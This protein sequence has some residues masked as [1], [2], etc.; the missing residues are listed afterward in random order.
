M[1]YSNGYG[2]KKDLSEAIKWYRLAAD[3]EDTKA[4]FMLGTYYENGD[5]VEKDYFEAFKWYRLAADHGNL[6]AQNNLGNCYNNG[7]GVEKD[8]VQ[9]VMWYR[10]AAEQNHATAQY[11]LG[12][13]YKNGEGV[14]KDI[15]QAVKWY[16]LAAEKGNVNAQSNLGFSFYNGDG[17]EKDFVQAVKWYSLAAE[18]G[19]ENAQYNLG[20]CYENGDGVEKDY[21][22]AFKWYQLS[23]E[24][25]NEY[26]Q[27]NLGVCYENG[28]G[29]EKDYIQAF[30]WYQLS[31]EQGNGNAQFNLGDCYENGDGVE[32]DYVQAVNWFRLAAEKGNVSAQNNLGICYKKGQGVE[33][34][35]VQAVYWYR[36]AAEKGNVS[37]QN[38]LG[39]CFENGEGVEKDF[40][41][42]FKWYQLS[43][44]QGN[45]NAQFNLGDC[46]YYGNGV[47][48][49]KSEALK[50]YKL[51]A[52]QGYESAIEKTKDLSIFTRENYIDNVK[53]EISNTVTDID[54]NVYKTVQIGNQIWMAENLRVSRYRNGDLIPNIQNNEEWINLE[55]GA[56][57]NYDNQPAYDAEYGKHYNWFAVNDKRG[58]APKGW[59]VPNDKE[60]KI[61]IDFLG[62]DDAASKLKKTGTNHWN[63][64]KEGSITA[65]EFSAIPCGS[66]N[67]RISTFD[68]VG[69][70]SYW[71]TAAVSKTSLSWGIVMGK[72]LNHYGTDKSNGLSVRCIKDESDHV[73][74]IDS[75]EYKTVQI[76]NQ[77]WMA[78]N[79]KVSKY[80]NGDIIH[81]E[82]EDEKWKSLN[83]GACCNYDNDPTN[84]SKYGKLYNW[85]AVDDKRGL[86]PKGWHVP[87]D[88]EWDVLIE[89]LGYY[90][91]A[92]RKLKSVG[93]ESWLE[94]NNNATNES[95]FSA[96][97]GGY[98]DGDGT[99]DGQNSNGDWWSSTEYD[100]Y[101][102][103]DWYVYCNSSNVVRYNYGKQCGFSVRCV[104]DE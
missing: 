101:Y 62:G 34:D 88:E 89:F 16:R 11:N 98:R 55:T 76:G 2:V 99:F 70:L 19:N 9:A 28:D 23:A 102:A 47:T 22:Q 100:T 86:A 8:C 44:E 27:N 4:Q 93:N 51:S 64:T 77:V 50:W 49:D 33:K 96:L 1:Y 81:N 24:Q 42:A 3:Q 52:E 72:W 29:V 21:I 17:I 53:S 20:V 18:Q 37:A 40:F 61:L 14:E 104:K 71:W 25:G 68:D 30:K 36:L 65:C 45:E 95:G 59:H 57:C 82:T 31:A 74:D 78:E 63:V 83:T 32:K 94:E 46:Y 48:L 92:G 66:R 60:W 7:K 41:Q 54:G 73:T 56:W 6:D 85:F 69:S 79:L 35:Y 80:R 90:E 43:A 84:N 91:I 39:V 87:N 67:G 13:C 12:A 10:L 15:L 26:A 5:G 103:W 97:P 38:N 58:L 75:N